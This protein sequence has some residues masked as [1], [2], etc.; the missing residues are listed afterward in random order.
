MHQV[1]YYIKK[2]IAISSHHL[3][4]TMLNS[5]LILIYLTPLC[6]TIHLELRLLNQPEKISASFKLVLQFSYLTTN[7][8]EL[9]I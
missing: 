3:N 9:A 8:D 2:I 7:E 6:L 5:K 4:S 1:C